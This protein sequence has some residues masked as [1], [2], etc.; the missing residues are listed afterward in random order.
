VTH[1]YLESVE[2]SN[3]RVYGDSFTLDLPASP[4]ITLIAGPNGIGKTTF[5]DGIEWCLTGNVS[6]FEPYIGAVQRKRPE[7]LDR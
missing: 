1:L 5:F 3:F 2:L 6:R 7:H 4:G